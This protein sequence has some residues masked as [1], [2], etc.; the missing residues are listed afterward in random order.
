MTRQHPVCVCFIAADVWLCSSHRCSG[1][2]RVPRGGE[3]HGPAA[4]SGVR[5]GP[6]HPLRHHILLP[7]P[8]HSVRLRLWTSRRMDG[9]TSQW[10]RRLSGV[11]HVYVCGRHKL[12]W[13]FSSKAG[14]KR[15]RPLGASALLLPRSRHSSEGTQLRLRVGRRRRRHPQLADLKAMFWV[16]TE[17]HHWFVPTAFSGTSRCLRG[18]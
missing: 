13:T 11:R 7:R 2:R 9:E 16:F 4:G 3:G 6:D 18:H 10:S 17:L 1:G 8:R 14:C 15:R 12:L 5:R